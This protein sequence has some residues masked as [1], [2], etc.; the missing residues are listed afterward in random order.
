MAETVCY[1]TGRFTGLTPPFDSNGE[2]HVHYHDGPA[3]AAALG[4]H[5]ASFS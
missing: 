1:T 4:A 2:K 5:A 3:E